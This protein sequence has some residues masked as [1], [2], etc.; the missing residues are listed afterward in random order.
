ML[1]RLDITGPG[2]DERGAALQSASGVIEERLDVNVVL[3]A[4]GYRLGAPGRSWTVL[5]NQFAQCGGE[6]PDSDENK[7][8]SQPRVET[9]PRW[10]DEAQVTASAV[11]ILFDCNGCPDPGGHF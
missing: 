9:Y 10:G 11:K 2:C 1:T 4:V 5:L 6:C 3:G 8:Y 7:K